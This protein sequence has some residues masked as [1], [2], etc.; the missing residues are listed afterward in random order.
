M[1][2]ATRKYFREIIVLNEDRIPQ[3]KPVL[4]LC[5]H[6]SAFMDPVVVASHLKREC[7]FIA[8]GEQFRNKIL[9][10][11][12]KGVNMIPI[13]RKEHTPGET[14]KND[15]IFKYC[16]QLMLDNGCLM[17]FPE[18]LCQTKYILAPLKTGAARIALES[19]LTTNQE[20]YMVPV[21]INYT[22]PHRFRGRV[23]INIGE[24][25]TTNPFINS[26]KNSYWDT[27][28]S[29]TDRLYEALKA[30][31]VTVEDEK[32]I[33]LICQIE[34]LI[35]VNSNLINAKNINWYNRRV[36]ILNALRDLQQS[37]KAAFNL[38]INRLQTYTFKKGYTPD[39]KQT[40]LQGKLNRSFGFKTVLLILGFPLF[41]IGLVL[42]I[43]PYLITR[44]MSLRFV[45]RVDFMGSF[46]FALGLLIFTLC[47]LIESYF[48]HHQLEIWWLTILFMVVWV[49]IGLFT[50]SF[51]AEL[52]QWTKDIQWFKWGMFNQRGKLRLQAERNWLLA[53]IRKMF[54]E[55]PK[56]VLS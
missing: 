6:R 19:A 30:T 49:P 32:E 12:Y 53:E 9:V 54:E 35:D 26:F 48:I 23:T 34:H 20:I 15:E 5:N 55:E 40:F 7:H 11:F 45:K 27:V 33:E 25:I 39:A 14:H 8:R 31:I 51:A 24:S 10:K 56:K 41:L 44:T 28:T 1:R 36:V 17:I 38:F 3:D 4:L 37:N 50:F 46:A 2:Y 47:G 29:L 21:G 22:N 16:T 52:V 42:H 13:Y 43:I 18:G